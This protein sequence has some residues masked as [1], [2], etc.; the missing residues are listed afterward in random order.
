MPSPALLLL[1][2]CLAAVSDKKPKPPNVVYILADDLGYGDVK[3][4]NPGGKIATPNLDLLASQGMTFTDAHSGS[5][6][7]TPTRYGILTGRYAWRSTLKRGVLGG[8]SPRLIEDGRLTVPAL[9][10][11][12]GYHTACVGKWH[13]GMDF[14]LKDGGVAKDYPDAWKVDYAK[15]IANGP[16]SVGFDR[17]FGISAS[18]DMPPYVFIENDRFQGVPTVEK[19]WIRSGPATR[20][21]EAIDVLPR[22]TEKAT[23]YVRERAKAGAPFFLYLPLT[24]PHTPILL[25]CRPPRGQVRT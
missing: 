8:Y 19:K 17:Y 18:L 4:L 6:V 12:H 14:P 11:K 22:L 3:C 13:L 21:F 23:T 5:S 16:R 9:L 24:S 7:C 1:P 15:P 20:E 25:A 10:K 2:L